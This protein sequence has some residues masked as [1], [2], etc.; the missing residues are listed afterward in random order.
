MDD[1]EKGSG[2]R[3]VKAVAFGNLYYTSHTV[4]P[5]VVLRLTVFR[6]W[7]RHPLSF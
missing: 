2:I 4:R 6:V 5:G 3:R 7:F 1:G